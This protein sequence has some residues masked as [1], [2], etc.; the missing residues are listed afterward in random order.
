[1]PNVRK[2]RKGSLQFWPRVRSKRQYPRIK[3]WKIEGNGLLGFAGY[4]V[5]MTHLTFKDKRKTALT[6]GQDVTFPVTVVECPPLKVASLRF[7]KKSSDGLKAV[8]EIFSQ[9]VDK[10]L[11]RKVML[12]KK[13]SEKKP[14][15]ID[16]DEVRL[17]VYTQPKLT[18]IGKKKPEIFEI[19]IGGKKEEQLKYA[20]EKIGKEL[21]IEDVFKEGQQID[22]HAVTKGKGFQ[23]PMKRF[24]IALRAS[25]SEKS[26]RN[27][28]SLGP[29]KG[30]GHIMWK[31]AHAGKMGY[32]TRTEYNKQILKIGKTGEDINI[33]GGYLRYG[34]VKNPYILIKG[35]VPGI[36]KRLIR[37]SLP[38][39]KNKTIVEE[40]LDINYISLESKQGN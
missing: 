3:N 23:G 1:M 39:R 34:N 35:S 30:Q 19:A 29:W 27:P 20:Q 15:E 18:G 5:G 24:G 17:L 31:V 2:P 10:E 36:S 33:A 11:K 38:R 22:L 4:K 28:G 12:P 26:R 14:E 7:Y 25:K 16:F 13:K 32:H 21:T 40:A 9:N 6:K 37:M 8:S